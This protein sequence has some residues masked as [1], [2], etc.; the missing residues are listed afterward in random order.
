MSEGAHYQR[1]A[2]A[3]MKIGGTL[4]ITGG[5]IFAALESALMGGIVAATGTAMWA[6]AGWVAHRSAG[7]PEE[8][9]PGEKDADPDRQADKAEGARLR[10]DL[11]ELLQEH[12]L[13]RIPMPEETRDLLREARQELKTIPG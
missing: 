6:G 11:R 4:L 8:D 5:V 3:D 12:N 10:E 9:Q 7:A 13:S 2:L 1:K